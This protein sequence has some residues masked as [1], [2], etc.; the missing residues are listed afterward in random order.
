MHQIMNSCSFSL[1]TAVTFVSFLATS[2]ASLTFLSQTGAPTTGLAAAS[3]ACVSDFCYLLGGFVVP[4]H[5]N[6]DP[7]VPNNFVATFNITTGDWD[8]NIPLG[9]GGVGPY[10]ASSIVYD[11]NNVGHY[12]VWATGGEGNDGENPP[13]LSTSSTTAYYDPW[14]GEWQV[15]S[16]G[17]PIPLGGSDTLGVSKHSLVSVNSSLF[18][19]GGAFMYDTE[20]YGVSSSVLSFDTNFPQG[21]IW[22]N[23]SSLVLPQPT[24]MAGAVSIDQGNVIFVAGG[25]SDWLSPEVGGTCSSG[26]TVP[27]YGD[28]WMLD[29]RSIV[30]TAPRDNYTNQI[31][32]NETQ[33]TWQ[34]LNPLNYPRCGLS[35]IADEKNKILYAIGGWNGD[36]SGI[37][38]ALNYSVPLSAQWFL[39]HPPLPTSVSFSGI[40]PLTY[41]P[42]VPHNRS[43][44]NRIGILSTGFNGD[45]QLINSTWIIEG[46]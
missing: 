31:L 25:S 27:P 10:S 46:F 16:G 23:L 45:N 19:I 24:C 28:V 32:W 21:S 40:T 8:T 2:I 6:D 43:N 36:N 39:V 18:L 41:Q 37:I 14:T 20:N 35:L 5:S 12:T 13:G 1:F 29:L 15:S 34:P 44:N 33:G 7:Y 11:D 42:G 30:G 22:M 38:E 3:T 26:S 17:S 9:I 4:S